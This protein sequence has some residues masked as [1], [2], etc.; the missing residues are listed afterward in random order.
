MCIAR[1]NVFDDS[2]YEY[3]NWEITK[4]KNST[5]SHP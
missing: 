2:Y 4:C 1:T 5:L 3:F